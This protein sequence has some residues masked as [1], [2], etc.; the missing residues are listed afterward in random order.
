MNDD[1]FSP[2]GDPYPPPPAASAVDRRELLL[3]T[4]LL[5]PAVA[6]CLAYRRLG[7]APR[8][9]EPDRCRHRFCRYYAG[10]RAR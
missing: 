9:E 5:A 10:E 1:P 4:L 6:G 2:Q 3:A 7:C 8:S